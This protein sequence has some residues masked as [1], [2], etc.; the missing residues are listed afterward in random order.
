MEMNVK[1]VMNEVH[2]THLIKLL[3]LP[4]QRRFQ[5]YQSRVLVNRKRFVVSKQVV[6]HSIFDESIQSYVFVFGVDLRNRLTNCCV[7]K[8]L[9]V[10]FHVLLI[11]LRTLYLR[12]A[13]C[14]IV[15]WRHKVWSVVIVVLNADIENHFNGLLWRPKILHV[16]GQR[17]VSIKLVQFSSCVNVCVPWINLLQHKQVGS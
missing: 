14:V 15:N 8:N 7:L 5:T 9:N 12:H 11:N 13:D 6:F 1:S 17:I 10:Q 16:D 3:T 2:S 4:V